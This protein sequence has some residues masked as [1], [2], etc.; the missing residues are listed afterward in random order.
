MGEREQARG[1]AS[2]RVHA[3]AHA[4]QRFRSRRL[5]RRA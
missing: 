2:E 5:K 3:H 1:A 4:E